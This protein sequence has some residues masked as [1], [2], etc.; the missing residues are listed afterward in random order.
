M[1]TNNQ[2][3][4]GI[5]VTDIE[6]AKKFYEEELGLKVEQNEMGLQLHVAGNNPIFVYEK[7]DHQP[8]NYTV[9]NFIVEDIDKTMDE[10]EANG[11]DFEHYGDLGNGAVPDE[12]GILRG[13]AANMGPDIAWFKDSSGNI[14][15][16]LQES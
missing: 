3:F 9:L 7:P 12:R 11:V 5:A 1:L 16:I 4:S 2:A 13:L 15:S 6:R 14:F 10:L 8:A